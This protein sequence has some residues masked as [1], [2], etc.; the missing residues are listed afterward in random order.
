[1]DKLKNGR[2]ITIK[3]NGEKRPFEEE[4]STKEPAS[5]AIENTPTGVKPVFEETELDEETVNEESLTEAAASQELLDESFDWILPDPETDDTEQTETA[6]PKKTKAGKAKI[7]KLTS[8]LAKDKNG[9]SGAVKSIFLAVISAVIVGTGFGIVMLKLVIS[10][11]GKQSTAARPIA[12]VNGSPVQ[13]SSNLST[14]ALNSWTAYVVQGGVFSGNETAK[15]ASENII[16][17]GFPAITVQGNGEYYLFLGVSD[18]LDDA[19]E[20]EQVYRTNG[21]AD[22][23]SKSITI[24]EK[25]IAKVSEGEKGLLKTSSILFPLLTKVTSGS[26][27]SGK[28]P[29]DL[30][31]SINLLETSIQ[32]VDDKGVNNA[33]IKQLKS[34]IKTAAELTKEF[35]TKQDRN[36]LLNAQQHL[37]NVLGICYSF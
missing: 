12:Q 10:D 34:E 25:T 11:Q 7:T 26:I 31:K 32:K 23:Y 19:K 21:I 35:Q 3:I 1:V 20:L 15:T 13:A 16:A 9:R 29:D 5:I 4:A 22:V 6:E 14:A 2:T 18:S 17:K 33:K 24:P 30:L 8:V 36:T 27:V 28:F 37:L